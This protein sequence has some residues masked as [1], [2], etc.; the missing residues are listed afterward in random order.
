MKSC[1][2]KVVDQP[3][4][5]SNCSVNCLRQAR[6]LALLSRLSHN[7]NQVAMQCS[8]SARE[9]GVSIQPSVERQR[10]PGYRRQQTR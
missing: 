3:D 1:C 10:N 2:E 8:F 9:V 4:V 7:V 6:K 5:F